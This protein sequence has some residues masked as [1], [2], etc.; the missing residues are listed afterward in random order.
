MTSRAQEFFSFPDPVNESSARV[1]AAGVVAM[2][3]TSLAMRKPWLMIPLAYGFAARVLTGPTASPLGQLATRVVTPRLPVEDKL[4][5]GAPKRLAQGM[6][7][8]M[9]GAALAL[10]YGLNR[11][12]AARVPLAALLGA[13]ALEAGLGICLACKMF[14]L[15]VKAGLVD[16]A[17]CPD[18]SDVTLR[19]PEAAPD[20]VVL[21]AN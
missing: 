18:C 21:P 8:A 1:V 4:V 19:I 14:P 17:D 20:V 10:H 2:A 6:G 3:G 7:L 15:L 13:A 12:Q 11:P 9:S 5:P 16:E